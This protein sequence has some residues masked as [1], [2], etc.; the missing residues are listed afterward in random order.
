[1]DP[2]EH[3]SRVPTPPTRP[4][5]GVPDLGHGVGLRR[6]HFDRVLNGA[7]Q[8]DWFEIISENFMVKGGRPLH[9]LERVRENYPI[10]LHGV[11]LSIGS[12]SPLDEDYLDELARLIRDFEPAWVSDHLCWTGVGGRNAHDLLPLPYTEECLRHVIER[13]HRVQ[14]HLGRAIALENVSTYLDFAGSTLTEWDFLA[15]IARQTDCGI[16][17]DVN[18]IYVNAM[19]HD[20]DPIRYLDA[21]P[22]KHVWQIHLAGHRDFGTHLLDTHSRNVCDEVWQLYRSATER[23]GAVASLIEWDEDVPEWDLLEAES[24]RARSVRMEVLTGNTAAT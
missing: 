24:L 19:N 5:S 21:I 14:Q 3:S 15:E 23:F 7:T 16:L 22:R 18:N 13:V 8:I 2:R 10:A 20:F 12:S 4:N 17:L 11:S 6:E 9:V 1:M